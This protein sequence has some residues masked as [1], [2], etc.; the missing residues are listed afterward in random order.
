[1]FQSGKSIA[2]VA[3]QRGLVVSTIEGHLSTYVK[4]GTLNIED[5][6]KP[7]KVVVIKEKL[8]KLQSPGLKEVKIALGDDYSYGEIKMVIASLDC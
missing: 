6:I 1:M 4:N 3:E 8:S 2:E 7:E 5:I